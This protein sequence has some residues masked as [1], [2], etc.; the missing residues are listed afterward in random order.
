MIRSQPDEP[1]KG[2]NILHQGNTFYS[3]QVN[4]WCVVHIAGALWETA[5]LETGYWE[6][7]NNILHKTF[8]ARD[9]FWSLFYTEQDAIKEHFI[10][11]WYNKFYSLRGML[12]ET[13]VTHDESLY[14]GS[15]KERVQYRI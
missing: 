2:K 9:T 3:P 10:G 4:H 12:V 11:K 7:N 6:V 13:K 14:N 15:G 8:K 5:I 1:G